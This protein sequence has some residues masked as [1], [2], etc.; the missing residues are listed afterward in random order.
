MRKPNGLRLNL[1]LFYD[2]R[3]N[4]ELYPQWQK[5]LR[6][7]Q[8]KTLIFWGEHDPFFPKA[9]NPISRTC[10]GPRLPAERWPLCDRGQSALYRRPHNQVLR[11][12]REAEGLTARGAPEASLPGQSPNIPKQGHA[13]TVWSI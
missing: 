10:R 8:P 11:Q 13:M 1:D 6:D 5:F 3:T 2:Y 4:V 7:H 9:A 12:E